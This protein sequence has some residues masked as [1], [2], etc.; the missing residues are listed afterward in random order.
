MHLPLLWLTT[1]RLCL[2]CDITCKQKRNLKETQ[3]NNNHPTDKNSTPKVRQLLKDSASADKLPENS[4]RQ[5]AQTLILEPANPQK[6]KDYYRKERQLHKHCLIHPEKSPWNNIQKAT[7]GWRYRQGRELAGK[8]TRRR[9]RRWGQS[10]K[11]AANGPHL[12]GARGV[13]W[14]IGRGCSLFP[15]AAI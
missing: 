8:T 15:R 9:I 10:P 2:T 6:D 12:S 13:G 7:N 4:K 1:R 5:S 11:S 14:F 3:P